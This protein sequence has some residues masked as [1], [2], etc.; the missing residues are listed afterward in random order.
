MAKFYNGLN[1]VQLFSMPFDSGD[2]FKP[3]MFVTIRDGKVAFASAV[4]DGPVYCVFGDTEEP[5]SEASG[6]VGLMFG[7][8]RLQTTYVANDTYAAGDR[9]TIGTDGKLQKPTA[10]EPTFAVVE[11]IDSA[12]PLTLTVKVN[13]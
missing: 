13:I 11:S 6:S 3:G 1:N 4:G 12:S 9:L 8:F 2:T 10:S 7:S 5:S